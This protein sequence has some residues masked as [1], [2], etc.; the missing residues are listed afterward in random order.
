MLACHYIDITWR[1]KLA[2]FTIPPKELMLPN[3]SLLMLPSLNE[4]LK[5]D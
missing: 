2:S 3:I 5:C 4:A 1:T